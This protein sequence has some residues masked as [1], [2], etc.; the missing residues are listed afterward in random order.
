AVEGDG[1]WAW[2]GEASYYNDYPVR[3]EVIYRTASVTPIGTPIALEDPAFDT[4]ASGDDPAG[5]PPLAQTFADGNGEVF[6]VVTNHF[7]SK[8]S[9]CGSLGD[10]DTGDGSGNCNLTRVAQSEALLE[11]VAALQ[12]S[13]HDDDVLII[14]DLNSYAKEAPISALEA[15]GFTN[16]LALYDGP[17]EYTYVFDGQLGNL[18]HALGSGSI[19]SQ[20]TGTAAWHINSDEPDILDYDMSFKKD[21]Q[22][23]LFEPNAYRASDHD[24]VIVGLDLTAASDF[25]VDVSPN[26]LWPPNHKYREVTVSGVDDDGDLMVNILGATSSELDCCY[27]DDDKPVDIV[28]T[29]MDTADLRA[30][31][32]TEVDGRVY[33]LT[34]YAWDGEGQAVLTSVYVH[35]PHDQRDKKIKN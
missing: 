34:V 32:Y 12:A 2:T 14:G 10:P 20:V 9:S 17:W 6:T 13:T 23:A 11:F 3:N 16:L 19:L 24:P 28:I 30:E 26:S 7:K 5:R 29:G 27:D 1:T 8:G 21:V 22:D 35:V 31:R 15:G 18:D 4:P 25:D 33:A